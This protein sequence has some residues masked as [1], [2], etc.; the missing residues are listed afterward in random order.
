MIADMHRG[1]AGAIMDMYRHPEELIESME[2]LVPIAIKE[3]LQI[4]DNSLSPIIS[5]PLHKGDDNFMSDKQFEKFYWPTFRKVLIGLINEGL[6]PMPFAE[7][8]FM[9]RL[10]IIKDMPRGSIIWYFE[11]TDLR[12]AKKVLG[13]HA[14]IAGNVPVS[15]LC[16]GT[17]QEVKEACRK[18]IEIAAPGGGYILA[19]A[20]SM[21]KGNPENLRA[22]IEAAQ[23]YGTY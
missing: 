12:T 9:R 1:T 21:N 6:V 23:E 11:R 14:C 7:G 19:G 2:K 8:S 4:A 15:I 22:M 16:T 13:G 3:A 10:D 5:M 17:P 18:Q 20:A